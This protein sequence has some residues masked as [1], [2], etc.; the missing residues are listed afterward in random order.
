M[1][2]TI[3]K[4]PTILNPSKKMLETMD[5]VWSASFVCPN[6]VPSVSANSTICSA[7]ISCS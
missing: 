7:S 4:T 1:N 2:D 3:K 5:R 6:C